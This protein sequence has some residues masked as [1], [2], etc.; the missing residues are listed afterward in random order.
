MTQLPVLETP[1]TRCSHTLARQGARF[2]LIDGIQVL[3]YY[4]GA[5]SLSPIVDLRDDLA[6]SREV[7]EYVATHLF[8]RPSA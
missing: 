7:D 8:A 6:K 1:T 5:E 2:T 4:S 3:A